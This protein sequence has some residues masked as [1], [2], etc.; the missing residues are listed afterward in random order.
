MKVRSVTV[1]T[2]CFNAATRV[3]RTAASI[4]GQTAVRSGRLR[5][6]YLVCDGGST[7]GTLEEVRRACGEVA[8]IRSEPDRGMY[9]AL[10]KGLA[11]ATGDVV[12]YLNAGDVYWPWALDVVADVLESGAAEWVTGIQVACAEDGAVVEATLPHRFRRRLIRTGWYGGTVL[13]RHVQQESTFWARSLHETVDL[14]ALARLR[15][16]GDHYLW[17][18]F[19]RRA[20]L[21][22]VQSCLGAFTYHRGQL[23]EDRA[24]YRREVASFTERPGPGDRALALWDGLWWHL[25]TRCFRRAQGEVIRYRL[26]DGGWAAPAGGPSGG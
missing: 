1:I 2:P 26:P 16:A 5:L 9:D 21:R 20:E 19:A 4:A 11:R 12:A 24:G 10:A 13:P 6:Q 15:L 25:G 18:C 14:E 3:G 17:C 22:L 23:S 7:D 8:E